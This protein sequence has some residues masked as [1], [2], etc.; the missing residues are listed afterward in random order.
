[1][2]G[3]GTVAS[4]RIDR[5]EVKVGDEVE[6]IGLKDEVKKTTITGLEMF[7]KTLD[8]GEAGDNVGAL[9]RGINRDEVVRGQVLA[10]PGSIQT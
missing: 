8:V 1:I 6:I 10:A 4:G 5:G 2:T 7:R 9:L 3:R